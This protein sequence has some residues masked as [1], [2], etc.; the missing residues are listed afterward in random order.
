MANFSSFRLCLVFLCFV[1]FSLLVITAVA[2]GDEDNNNND[3]EAV[4]GVKIEGHHG[5]ALQGQI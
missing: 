4:C 3:N 5:F 2:C 1:L